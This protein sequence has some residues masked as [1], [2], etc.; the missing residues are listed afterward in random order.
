M[1]QARKGHPSVTAKIVQFL[2]KQLYNVSHDK[3]VSL[4]QTQIRFLKYY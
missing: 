2:S 3:F 1:K 4:R